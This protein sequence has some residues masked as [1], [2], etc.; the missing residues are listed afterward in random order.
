MKRIMTIV[1]GFSN[2]GLS[3]LYFIL[4]ILGFSHFWISQFLDF[5]ILQFLYFCI[6]ELLYFSIFAFCYFSIVVCYLLSSLLSKKTRL[7]ISVG[8]N[9]IHPFNSLFQFK[10]GQKTMYQLLFRIKNQ[11][12]LVNSQPI[13]IKFLMVL[14]QRF[15]FCFC[16]K[17]FSMYF[18]GNLYTNNPLLY[19]VLHTISPFYNTVNVIH[20]CIFL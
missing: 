14:K 11:I 15:V 7:M 4:C 1:L 20:Y 6:F 5:C 10:K 12:F 16:S 3:T 8:L 18:R 19:V 13:Y 9:E 2:A 17:T